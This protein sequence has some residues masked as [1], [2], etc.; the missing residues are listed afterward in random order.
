M[1]TRKG[2]TMSAIASGNLAAQLPA[3]KYHVDPARSVVRFNT[4]HMF[5]LSGVSGTFKLREAELTVGELTT[6]TTLDA[7]I[8]AASV[9]TGT[10]KRDADV[11]S[12]KYLDVSTYPDITF[13]SRSISQH[14]GEWVAAGTVT[15]HGVAAP[16]GLTLGEVHTESGELT[17]RATARIDRY[18]HQIT[19]GKGL[20]ARWLTIEITAVVSPRVPP[21]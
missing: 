20:A 5:G 18:A 19:A 10:A 17:L 2:V 16:V 6:D 14:D 9:D 11:R 8:D 3:G 4:R 13:V 21:V 15:A 12:A 7:V 1:Q